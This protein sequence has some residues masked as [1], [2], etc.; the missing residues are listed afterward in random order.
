MRREAKWN[1]QTVEPFFQA[2]PRLCRSACFSWQARKCC[3]WL[4]I[5]VGPQRT[6]K[7]ELV[8]QSGMVETS[9][10]GGG[11]LGGEVNAVDEQKKHRP[12]P[13]SGSNLECGGETEL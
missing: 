1:R 3:P 5:G 4:S 6:V 9:R 12:D 11:Q 7:I 10:L 13:S 8:T 2:D